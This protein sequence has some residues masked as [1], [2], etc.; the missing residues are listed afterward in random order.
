MD[1]TIIAAIIGLSGL[2]LGSLLNGVGFFLRERYQRLRIVNKSIF[3]LLKLL[4]MNSALKST[5]QFVLE[6]SQMLKE[7]PDTKELMS[8]NE[9]A[10]S[11]YCIQFLTAIINPIFHNVNEE[12]KQ[13]FN[14]SIFELSNVKPVVA[15]ELSKTSYFEALSQEITQ[16]LQNSDY[17]ATYCQG[18]KNGFEKGVKA[19]QRHILQEFE[20]RIING[21]KRLS[22]STNLLNLIACR[23]KIFQI[24][25]K[26]SEKQRKAYLARYFKETI[27]P[28]M[29]PYEKEV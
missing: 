6:Y 3:Y 27:T 29:E 17:S 9:N 26:F 10:L 20:N 2:F 4:H 5:E 21:L 12:F 14:D 28:L 22:W 11:Q 23:F 25:N 15:Y 19:S 16:I 7:H 8:V 13:K 1:T 18:D 24:K